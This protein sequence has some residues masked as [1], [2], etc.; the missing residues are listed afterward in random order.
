MNFS[1]KLTVALVSGCLGIASTAL[2]TT[3][4]AK[5]PTDDAMIFGTSAGADTGNANG[6]GPGMFAGA[7]GMGNIKRSIVKWDLSSIPT[8]ATLSSVEVDLVI[9]QIAGSGGMG[10]GCGTSC[11]PPSRTFD[12]YQVDYTTAWHEGDTGETACPTT[13]LTKFTQLCAVIGATG[14]GWPYASCS[15]RGVDASC[16]N[17][18]SWKYIDFTTSTQWGNSPSDQDYGTGSFGSP[19]FGNH[20]A[21]GTWTFNNFLNNNTMAFPADATNNL[22]FFNVV[23]DWVQHPS[24]NNGLE[25]RAPGLEGTTTSFIGWWTK[26]GVNAPSSGLPT[27][28]YP[29]LTVNY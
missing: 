16:G 21:A 5:P 15:G 26:D 20:T 11:T 23:K 18:T 28:Y 3:L 12:F 29:T 2:A 27:S 6:M 10:S 7:D 13:G 25:I 19:S 4:N 14:Q 22:G 17:D 9:G 8:T 24:H 1:T